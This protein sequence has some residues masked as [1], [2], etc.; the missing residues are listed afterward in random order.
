MIIIDEADDNPDFEEASELMINSGTI[1]TTGGSHRISGQ[2]VSGELEL[3]LTPEGERNIQDKLMSWGEFEAQGPWKCVCGSVNAA[4]TE[5]C[6]CGLERPKASLRKYLERRL[7]Q[8][9]EDL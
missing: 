7:E 2:I 1:T 6:S 8:T 4:C 9:K 5:W 3:E